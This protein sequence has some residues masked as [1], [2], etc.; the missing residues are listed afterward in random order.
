MPRYIVP[1]S[2]HVVIEAENVAQA[3]RHAAKYKMIGRAAGAH[4]SIHERDV[5]L[6]ERGEVILNMGKPCRSDSR[7]KV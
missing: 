4:R 5:T 6:Y 2:G 7:M 3:A 1:F